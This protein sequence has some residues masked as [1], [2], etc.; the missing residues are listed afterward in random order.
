MAV[1]LKRQVAVG[2]TIPYRT[3]ENQNNLTLPVDIRSISL[4]KIL[5]KRISSHQ[6]I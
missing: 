3:G 1:F 6:L 2:S 4:K 5:K